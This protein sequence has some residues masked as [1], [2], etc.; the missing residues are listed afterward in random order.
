M[1][2]RFKPGMVCRVR[3]TD[4]D[5]LTGNEF[6]NGTR[7]VAIAAIDKAN[8]TFGHDPEFYAPIPFPV[9]RVY[10]IS[11]NTDYANDD[12]IVL[13]DEETPDSMYFPAFINPGMKCQILFHD[14]AEVVACLTEETMQLLVERTQLKG[15]EM[16]R[17]GNGV[18]GHGLEH[19]LF[20]DDELEVL[21]KLGASFFQELGF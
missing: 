5:E 17:A 20:M 7:F 15:R 11:E 2:E 4:I 10:L 18:F 8:E 3:F 14:I 21:A 13:K 6:I 1:L 9:A 12:D 16:S 19:D